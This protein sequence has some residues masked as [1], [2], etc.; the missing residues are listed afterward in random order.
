MQQQ[1]NCA[2]TENPDIGSIN[3][4]ECRSKGTIPAN[5][6]ERGWFRILIS[7]ARGDAWGTALGAILGAKIWENLLT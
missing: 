5:V 2:G 3:S 4:V 7:S 6:Q 1:Q